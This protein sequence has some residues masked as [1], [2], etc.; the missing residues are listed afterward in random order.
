MLTLRHVATAWFWESPIRTH[1]VL[2]LC[3]PAAHARGAASGPAL[4]HTPSDWA[5]EDLMAKATLTL[6]LHPHPHPHPHL[7]PAQA[8]SW[9]QRTRATLSAI[10]RGVDRFAQGK[11]LSK[12][13]VAAGLGAA[14]ETT[15]GGA[16]PA[17][18]LP[19]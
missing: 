8:T 17:R 2:R 6:T 15:E 12:A 7:D 9:A 5:Y 10:R 11:S 13:K 3:Q 19:F 14:A 18:R 16:A 4:P 1:V